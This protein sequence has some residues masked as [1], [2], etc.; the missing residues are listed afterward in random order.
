VLGGLLALVAGLVLVR[1]PE[2]TLLALSLA[3]GAVMLLNGVFR[4]VSAVRNDEARVAMACS[5]LFS[6]LLGLLVFTQWPT[7][8]LWLVGALLGIQLLVDGA[9]LIIVGRPWPSAA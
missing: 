6:L 4:L 2:A 3:I 5:G 7:S 9:T 8:A 1:N